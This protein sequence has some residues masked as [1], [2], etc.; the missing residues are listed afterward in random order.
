[1]CARLPFL[2]L[3]MRFPTILF[4]LSLS[5]RS[6]RQDHPPPFSSS[7]FS[8]ERQPAGLS[9]CPGCHARGRRRFLQEIVSGAGAKQTPPLATTFSADHAPGDQN[10]PSCP[11]H[12][13]LSRHPNHLSHFDQTMSWGGKVFVLLL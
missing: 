8:S 10:G 2:G 9:L 3:F 11:V 4:P 6:F 1:M 12:E 7:S 5:S 13:I